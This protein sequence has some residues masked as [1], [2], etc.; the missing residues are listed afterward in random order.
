M[1]W[2]QRLLI[3]LVLALP[4]AAEDNS[5]YHEPP[6]AWGEEE[7]EREEAVVVPPLPDV[8]Q[9]IALDSGFEGYRYFLDPGSLS[10]A[11]HRTVRYAVVVES[12]N[13]VRN[14][15]YEG[16]QCGS[17]QYK[18]Y[19]Y[20]AGEGPYQTTTAPEWKPIR[21]T[22]AFTYRRDLQEFY[23]CEGMTLRTNVDDIVRRIKYRTR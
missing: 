11:D 10:I 7:E 3:L 16:I 9:L 23:F 19:A 1:Q 12:P 20:A 21:G 5:W 17:R 22:T 2:T 18:T 8:R 13:G 15:L 6:K 14:V 4:A